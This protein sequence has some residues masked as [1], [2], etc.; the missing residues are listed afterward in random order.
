MKSRVVTRLA[1]LLPAKA[2]LKRALALIE[3]EQYQ[4][5][6][7]LLA[8][9]AQEGV[10]EAQYQVARAYLRGAGVPPNRSHGL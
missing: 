3:T 2:R 10:P 9:L 1:G 6:F 4:Q 8:S 7:P 5:A